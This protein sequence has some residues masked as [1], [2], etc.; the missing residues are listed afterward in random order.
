MTRICESWDSDPGNGSR[1][2]CLTQDRCVHDPW[3]LLWGEDHSWA[4][5]R[6]VL[7]TSFS[8]IL[9]PSCFLDLMTLYIPH[10]Q[11]SL[12]SQDCVRSSDE[13]GASPAR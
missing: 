1:A 3:L 10:P 4:P 8:A 12:S 5:P 9:A 7:M 2:M 11:L 13:R 6:Q